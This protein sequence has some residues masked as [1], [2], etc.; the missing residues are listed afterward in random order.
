MK[1]ARLHSEPEPDFSIYSNPDPYAYGSESS[2]PLL[3]IIEIAIIEIA[4]IEIEIADS[5]L[6][7]DRTMK[8]SL[9]ADIQVPEYWIINLVENVLEVYRDPGVGQF[10]SRSVLKTGDKIKP[11]QWS[12]LEI[13]VG[14]LIPPA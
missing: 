10:Q 12:D 4:I 3:I 11:L 1:E 6:E 2:S 14:E 13:E 7:Y 8:A 5:L 9:Y